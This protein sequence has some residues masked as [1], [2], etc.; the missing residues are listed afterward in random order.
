[1]SVHAGAHGGEYD[2]R[3]RTEHNCGATH[4]RGRGIQMT[5]D[6]ILGIVR[7]GTTYQVRYASFNP[8]DLDRPP[9][10]CPDE[11]TLVAWLRHCGMEPWYIHQAWTE[12]RKGG[13]AA[14]PIV[15]SEA[16]MQT[17]FP[18]HMPTTGEH[19]H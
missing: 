16:Q 18:V 11:G 15:L 12:L 8:R 2:L 6:G 10:Q 3:R 1:M 17:Y 13:F 7:C 4:V 14:L 19:K 9:Y 5:E